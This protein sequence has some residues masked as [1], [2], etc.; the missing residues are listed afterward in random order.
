MSNI[1][2]DGVLFEVSEEIKNK[3][4][5]ILT[6][7]EVSVDLTPDD[8]WFKTP[9][10]EWVKTMAAK[11]DN[12]PIA[13]GLPDPDLILKESIAERP[14]AYSSSEARREAEKRLKQL[15][16]KLDKRSEKW[17]EKLQ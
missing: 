17:E 8:D 10:K 1:I 4:L 13:A 15:N 9:D 2:V 16:D 5:E 14:K 11:E 3:V 6:N 7:D 12:M